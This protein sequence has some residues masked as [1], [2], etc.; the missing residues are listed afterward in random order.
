MN[1]MKYKEYTWIAEGGTESSQAFG[2]PE[3]AV[4]DAMAHACNGR[5]ACSGG[6]TDI[7]CLCG[8]KNMD[9]ERIV[10]A[11]V[12]SMLQTVE[13][14]YRGWAEIFNVPSS[15]SPDRA[16]REKAVEALLPLFKDHFTFSPS[17]VAGELRK[18]S[19][20]KRKYL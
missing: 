3:D 20:T 2:T 15:C 16:F 14:Q 9:L 19:L 17:Q 1:T 6:T 11:G 7:I 18:Y 4:A 5:V 13:E 12:S 10:K 8:V